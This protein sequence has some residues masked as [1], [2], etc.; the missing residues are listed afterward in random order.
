MLESVLENFHS[1]NGS[2]HR[3]CYLKQGVLK[4]F[5][6]FTGKYLCLRLFYNKVAGLRLYQKIY[7]DKGVFL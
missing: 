7:F 5:A 6:K 4:N 1:N 3:R 2:S